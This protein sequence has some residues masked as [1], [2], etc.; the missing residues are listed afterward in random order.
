LYLPFNGNAIE[1]SGNGNN[2]TV[3]GAT[4]TEDRFGNPNSAYHFNGT[5]DYIE[6]I[7]PTNINRNIIM[8]HI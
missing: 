4:L 7:N 6:I 1:E 3:N 2:G 5:S 8:R